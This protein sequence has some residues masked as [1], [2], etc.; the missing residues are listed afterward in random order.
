MK[1]LNGF[2]REAQQATAEY[3]GMFL[4]A[5]DKY[6]D[7]DWR[8]AKALG[9]VESRL[10]PTA[11][12]P[13]GATGIMQ[14]TEPTYWD[15]EDTS[16]LSRDFEARAVD[17]ETNIRVGCKYL[18]WCVERAK[19]M[20][21]ESHKQLDVALCM[22]NAGYGNVRRALDGMRFYEDKTGS[23]SRFQ[24]IGALW[25]YNSRYRA[26]LPYL[27]RVNIAY[28]VFKTRRVAS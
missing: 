9:F 2:I 20:T 16:V 23:T 4:L 25:L 6:P 7:I 11:K 18:N 13:I 24:L 22:Y 27:E 17:P 21:K 3:D 28:T 26:L 12:S 1:N 10:N 19:H 14:L 15:M 5:C 8:F